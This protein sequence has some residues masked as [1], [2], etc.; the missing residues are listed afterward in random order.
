MTKTIIV[1]GASRGIG[2][3]IAKG[4]GARG[5]RVC[6]NYN[7]SPDKA[8]AVAKAIEAAGGEAFTFKAN[9][10]VE[11]ELVA[12]YEA[13]DKRWGA[14]DG[15]CNNAGIDHE[16]VFADTT[17]DAYLK[18]FDV[19][20]LG[21]M[22]SCREAVRRM[23]T[24]RGGRGG[25]IVNIGSI[26]ARTGGL[27]GDVIYTATKGAVDA[28]TLGLAKEVGPDGIR[29]TCVRPGVIETDI[30]SGNEFGLDKVKELAKNNS[31]MRRIGQPQEVAAMALFLL[32][33]EAS[34][35]TGMTYD[36]NGGR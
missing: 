28:F 2:A 5:W 7:G 25:S 8:E 24:A 9:Q 6:V 14:P 32:S 33:D 3:A 11:G 36:V 4:A 29:V 35:C 12:M 22:A 1:T 23:S 10:G 30:F 21:L 19:N 18:V 27:P 26:S 15:V 34:F 20:I 31:P 16:A 17:W 13:V